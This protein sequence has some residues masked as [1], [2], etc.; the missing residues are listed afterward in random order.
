[1]SLELISLKGMEL[2]VKFVEA[3]GV[4]PSSTIIAA[5]VGTKTKLESPTARLCGGFT[6]SLQSSYYDV[7]E[8]SMGTHSSVSGTGFKFDNHY[9][10]GYD[11][12]P[13]L[14]T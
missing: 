8:A 14:D 3:D 1:M 12:K 6:S 7:L 13:N 4:G 10:L 5:N 9:H 11:H 2:Y